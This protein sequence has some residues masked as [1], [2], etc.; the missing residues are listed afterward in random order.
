MRDYKST[1]LVD[2]ETRSMLSKIGRKNQSY[3]QIIREL[4]ET[5][6]RVGLLEIDAGNF[7]SSELDRS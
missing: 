2:K 5:K 4:I 6:N 3:D 1:I 7:S